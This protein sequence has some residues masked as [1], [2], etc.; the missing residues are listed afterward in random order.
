MNRLHKDEI[1][2]K[3]ILFDDILD[4]VLR[5]EQANSAISCLNQYVHLQTAFGQ[6]IRSR[7]YL[8][9]AIDYDHFLA[10]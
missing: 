8:P 7:A 3:S 5:Y 1:F 9:I 10:E 6:C 2:L 4:E